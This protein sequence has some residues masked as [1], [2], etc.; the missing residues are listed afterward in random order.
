MDLVEHAGFGGVR[1]LE[2][3]KKGVRDYLDSPS[4][5]NS[6]VLKE[7]IDGLLKERRE[8]VIDGLLNC[9]AAVKRGVKMVSS[10]FNLN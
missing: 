1:A 6:K 7:T 4:E 10:K 2:E 3:V 9:S 5:E 8:D